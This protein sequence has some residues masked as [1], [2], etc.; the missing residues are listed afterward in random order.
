MLSDHICFWQASRL[1]ILVYWTLYSPFDGIQELFAWLS[2]EHVIDPIIVVRWARKRGAKLR[3][4]ERVFLG[5][6]NEGGRN[7]VDQRFV[8]QDSGTIAWLSPNSPEHIVDPIIVVRS[9]YD[10]RSY[11]SD[12]NAMNR[13]RK[14]AYKDH[15]QPC[16]CS[17]LLNVW[18]KVKE[19]NERPGERLGLRFIPPAISSKHSSYSSVNFWRR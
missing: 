17:L 5:S 6:K 2:P 3:A 8:W 13:K 9:H 19:E 15:I 4:D 11:E 18:D 10:R 14:T 7:V 16:V 12:W 1:L